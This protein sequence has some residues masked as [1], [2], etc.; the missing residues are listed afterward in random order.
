MA[1]Y[2]PVLLSGTPA[3][4]RVILVVATATPGTLIHTCVAGA[5][6]WDEIYLYVSNVTGTAATLTIEWGGVLAP[7][8][9]LVDTLSI[10]PN[11]PPIA[12]A[13][14]LRMNGGLIIRAYSG[15]A[16]ALNISGNCNRIA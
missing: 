6:A 10:P 1:T 9:H 4:G 5:A 16:S 12:L 2:T 3:S 7:G 15:T 11:S 13:T 14:G 8:D